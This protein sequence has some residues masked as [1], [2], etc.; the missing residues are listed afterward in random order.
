MRSIRK[1]DTKPEITVR[2][3]VHAL[4]YRFRLHRSD[5]PGTPDLTFV[6]ARKTIFVHGCFWHQHRGCRLAK[7]PQARPEYWLPKLARNQERDAAN[8]KRLKKL[9]W[10]A[11][12]LWECQ[13]GTT[14]AIQEKIKR[15]LAS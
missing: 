12:V 15:F 13:I 5:I 2:K 1:K 9:G 8:L 10:K 14:A 11:L 3:L 7:L 6:R 4:G